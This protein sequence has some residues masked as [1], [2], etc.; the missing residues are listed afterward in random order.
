MSGRAQEPA[1]NPAYALQPETQ[2]SFLKLKKSGSP[3]DLELSMTGLKMGSRAL[4]V[5]GEDPGLIAALAKVVGLSGHACAVS[6]T[7]SRTKAFEKAA[8]SEGVLVET[9]TAP[10]STIPYDND[11]FDLVVLKNILANLRQNERVLCVQEILRVL[12][13]GG[14]CVII[15][16]AMRGGIGSIFSKRSMDDRYMHNGGAQGALKNEGFRGVRILADHDGLMFIEGTKSKV[17]S[18]DESS[19]ATPY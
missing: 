10:L 11:Y 14:R 18:D 8:E 2:M 7:E 4:Q 3:R 19:V 16:P 1:G 6:D 15:D 12:R 9:K 17:S 13:V 5:G